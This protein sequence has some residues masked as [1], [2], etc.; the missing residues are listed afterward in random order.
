MCASE[1]LLVSVGLDGGLPSFTGTV[2]LQIALRGFVG[3]GTV[4]NERLSQS[5]IIIVHFS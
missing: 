4:V 3:S 1:S 5:Y 2:D